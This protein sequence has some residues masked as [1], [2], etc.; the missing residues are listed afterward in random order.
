MRMDTNEEINKGIKSQF[1]EKINKI[2]KPLCRLSKK[3]KKTYLIRN[4]STN[5]TTVLAEKFVKSL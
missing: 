5:I 4:E 3:Q 2:N 1:F